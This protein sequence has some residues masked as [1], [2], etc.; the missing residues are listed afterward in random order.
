VL[1][2]TRTDRTKL[3][4]VEWV[5]IVRS[6]VDGLPKYIRAFK[7]WHKILETDSDAQSKEWRIGSAIRTIVVENQPK[8][9]IRPS[10]AF[11]YLTMREGDFPFEG[12]MMNRWIK[13]KRD[14]G[15]PFG[16][17]GSILNVRSKH[18]V[19][20]RDKNLYAI[21]AMWIPRAKQDDPPSGAVSDFWY[22][23]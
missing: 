5:E 16:D 10:D 15:K 17:L 7:P 20:S 21:S 19:L 6:T 9:I 11:M 12:G 1:G 23:L 13:A 8:R 3:K 14:P 2:R 18:M 22:E 4:P